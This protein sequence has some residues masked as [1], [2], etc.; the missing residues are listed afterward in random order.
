MTTL[1][2]LAL[3]T[4]LPAT[5]LAQTAGTAQLAAQIGVD[6][7]RFSA[8]ELTEL[9][10]ELE[11]GNRV[12]VNLILDEAGSDL[13][14]DQLIAGIR[15]NS[16]DLSGVTDGIGATGGT[17]DDAAGKEQIAGALGVDP[18]AF[19]LNQLVQLQAAVDNGED[20]VIRDILSDAGVD[21]TVLTVN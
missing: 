4:V 17:A 3:A 18:D 9:R 10:A 5:A 7:N 12:G 2:A 19:T 20:N 8:V 1:S 11:D 16:V 15:E 14:Y 13:T 6:P 21:E